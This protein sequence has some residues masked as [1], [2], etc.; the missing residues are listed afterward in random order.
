MRWTPNDC[1]LFLGS[2]YNEAMGQ[3]EAVRQTLVNSVREKLEAMHEDELFKRF[4]ENLKPLGNET[5]EWFSDWRSD[6]DRFFRS[7]RAYH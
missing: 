5:K 3:Q 2:K 4:D 7:L 6:F 1:A